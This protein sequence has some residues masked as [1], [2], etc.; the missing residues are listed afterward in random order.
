VAYVELDY[1]TGSFWHNNTYREMWGGFALIKIDPFNT[2]PLVYMASQEHLF[3]R[4]YWS[5]LHLIKD[6]FHFLVPLKQA[7]FRRLGIKQ[8]IDIYDEF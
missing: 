4:A 7:I 6:P 1:I 3:Q 5:S 2:K 8:R